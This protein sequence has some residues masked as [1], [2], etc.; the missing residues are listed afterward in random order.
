MSGLMCTATLTQQSSPFS[1]AVLLRELHQD[2]A[3]SF[4]IRK[5]PSGTKGEEAKPKKKAK[6]GTR[7]EGHAARLFVAVEVVVMGEDGGVQEGVSGLL[8][9]EVGNPKDHSSQNAP[10]PPPPPLPPPPVFLL[11]LCCSRSMVVVVAT[12][13]AS[14]RRER[15]VK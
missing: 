15:A 7:Y 12:E 1:I 4:P 13:K 5:F 3:N 10:P 8:E 6:F 11:S 2:H 9:S 14:I